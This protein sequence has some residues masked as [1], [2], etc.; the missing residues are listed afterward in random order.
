MGADGAP[1]PHFASVDEGE[2]WLDERDAASRGVFTGSPASVGDGRAVSWDGV[3]ECV[4]AV[5]A[6]N[7]ALVLGP[8]AEWGT[9]A[10]LVR[11]LVGSERFG[12]DWRVPVGGRAFGDGVSVRG[13]CV[14]G[15]ARDVLFQHV[16][17]GA[18]VGEARGVR[19]ESVYAG[20]MV[21]GSETLFC[22]GCWWR[23]G[24]VWCAWRR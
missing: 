4:G 23:R 16:T 20:G 6:P 24:V 18:A 13:L 15:D 9:P 17:G 3:L 22:W 21:G 8:S 19:F 14:V 7:G 5:S 11:G 1:V 2:R 10:R 12:D